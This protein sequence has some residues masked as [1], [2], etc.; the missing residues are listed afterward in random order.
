M[1]LPL[2]FDPVSNGEYLPPRKT[3]R[4]AAMQEMQAAVSP[5][6]IDARFAA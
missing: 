5:P 4:V 3:A 2:H 1:T 6:V